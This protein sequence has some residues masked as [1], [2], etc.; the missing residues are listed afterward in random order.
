[1]QPGDPRLPRPP[2]PRAQAPGACGGRRPDLPWRRLAPSPRWAPLGCSGCSARASRDCR[3]GGWQG[4]R[5]AARGGDRFMGRAAGGKEALVSQAGRIPARGAHLSGQEPGRRRRRARPPEKAAAPS[6]PGPCARPDD[7]G[8]GGG[9]GASP[10]L[11]SSLPTPPGCRLR[12]PAA[13]GHR[14]PLRPRPAALPPLYARRC[15]ALLPRRQSTVRMASVL[16]PRAEPDL[17][18][19]GSWVRSAAPS[20]ASTCVQREI[21]VRTASLSVLR[22]GT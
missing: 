22:Q 18:F 21:P 4:G 8:G 14:W 1:M 15:A 16:G 13:L 10:S 3:E 12:C 11:Q 17:S 2:L 5:A 6:A 19:T 9:E 20:P 7:G